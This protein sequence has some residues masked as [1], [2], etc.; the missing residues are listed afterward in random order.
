MTIAPLLS[1]V[2]P[3]GPDN[4]VVIVGAGLA[5]LRTATGLR[6]AGFTGRVVLIGEEA[7]APYDRPPLSKAVLTEPDGERRIALAADD[8]IEGHAIDLRLAACVT[9]IDRHARAVVLADGSRVGYDRL[10]LATGSR[11]RTLPDMEPGTPGVH[12]LRTLDDA[13]ALR[14]EAREARAIAVIGAGV[15]GLEVAAAL[16]GDGAT[17]RT[18]TVIDPADRV[19]GRSASP[20]V[21]AYLEQRH[22]DA[23]VRFLFGRAV[24]ACT[25]PDGRFRLSLT[26]GNDLDVDILIVGIGVLPNAGLAEAAGLSVT[27]GGI[28]V[29]DAGR[30]DDPLIHAAGEVAVHPLGPDGAPARQETWAHAAAH[31]E[32]VAR[33]IMGDSRYEDVPSYW[34][35]QYDVTLQVIGSPIGARDVVRGDPATGQFVV[36]HLTGAVVTGVS[37]INSARELRRMK[38]L[39]GRSIADPDALADPAVDVATLT[40]TAIA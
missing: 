1:P 12:Y 20:A 17:H 29:D 33:A 18:V 27:S 3:P 15:I 26:D 39:L 4:A 2:T 9:A 40:A 19:M 13:L 30:T 10:V 25:R 14:A 24:S 37:A 16:A 31:G 36:L 7:H 6:D 38:P 8:E 35:D 28:V 21:S 22:R 23:G 11:V 5:G 34:S 32:H